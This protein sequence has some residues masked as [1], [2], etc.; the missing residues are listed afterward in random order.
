[1]SVEFRKIEYKDTKEI[2]LLKH[3]AHRLPS[4]SF[5][6]GLFYEGILRGVITFG[7]PA[8]NSLCV[9]VAGKEFSKDVIELNRLYIDDGISQAFK[10]V[11]SRFVAYALK[12]LKR[13][14]KIIVSYADSGM[15]HNGYIYQATNFLYTGATKPRTDIFS[16]FGK[17]SRHYDKDEE[18]KYRVF[19]SSKHRYIYIAGDKR[20]KAKVLRAL[21]YK[22]EDY[23]KG[24][25]RRYKVGDGL[26]RKYKRLSDNAILTEKELKKEIGGNE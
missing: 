23:P 6:F 5:S 14:N 24:E 11:T 1:M 16:G 20:F 18:Q 9:G 12:Q 4:I 22:I 26:E 17:H 21:R 19:R 2:L 3:Y 15:N 10:N 25:A 13:E 7:K 8:S